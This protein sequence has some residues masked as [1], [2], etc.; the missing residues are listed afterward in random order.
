MISLKQAYEILFS[1]SLQPQVEEID[2]FQCLKRV[3][4]E[5]VFATVNLPAFSN[6]AMDGYVVSEIAQSYKLT[7]TILAG[8]IPPSTIPQGECYKIMTGAKVPSNALAVIPFEN[9]NLDKE[10][11]KPNQEIKK[12]ANIKLEGEECKKGEIL[13]QKGE[14][15]TYQSLAL[16]ASQG[17]ATL[18]VFAPLKIAIYSSGDEVVELGEIAGEQQIYNVNALAYHSALN[19]YGF[20]SQYQGILRDD[21]EMIKKEIE[22]FKDFDIV[23]TSGGASVGEADF[24]EQA[25]LCAGAKILFH[26]INLKP[27]RPMLTA[28]LNKTY[29]FS[30]P[31]NPLS[32]LLNLITLSIPTLC[33]LSGSKQFTPTFI[34]AKNKTS[35]HLKNGRSN[36]I[37]GVFDGEYFEA[38][39][40]GKYGSGSILPIKE[41]N[42]IAIFD[43]HHSKIDEGVVIQILPIPFSFAK[44]QVLCDWI[45]L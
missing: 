6:S 43:E 4:A 25:L 24:F 40:A 15:L 26:G 1:Q 9:A 10:R 8:E 21:L 20:H 2:I 3:L 23:F 17:I 34:K 39:K 14:R 5:D 11:M 28:K 44:K 19:S 38:Y 41:S 33:K 35:F 45:N 37:L 29:I 36:M 42:A 31:G 13:L 7:H 30:L 22:S 27:G 12:G 18:K 32:G 16:L